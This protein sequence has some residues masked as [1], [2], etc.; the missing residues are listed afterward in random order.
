MVC[1]A[2]STCFKS[3][4]AV[5]FAATDTLD[6]KATLLSETVAVT[7]L[8]VVLAIAMLV[9]TAVLPDGVVYRVV[10]VVAAAVR[11][12]TLDVVA[13]SYYIPFC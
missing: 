12:S 9:T 11:A 2:E 8:A 3:I 6:N 13:I 5:V 4:N 1:D 10:L 7:A